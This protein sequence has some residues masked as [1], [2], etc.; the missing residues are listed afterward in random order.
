MV[1]KIVIGFVEGE[2]KSYFQKFVKNFKTKKPNI[3]VV[4]WDETLTSR[5]ARNW[6][7]KQQVPKTKRKLKEH[8]IA[9]SL[10]LQSYLDENA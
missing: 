10:I 7:I 2:I 3:E 6:M 1:D 5:Q 4:M 8:E 9:A